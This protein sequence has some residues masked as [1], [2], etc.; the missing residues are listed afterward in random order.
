[1]GLPLIDRR[2]NVAGAFRAERASV[3]G[4]RVVVVDDVVTTGS[5]VAELAR[6]LRRAGAVSVDVWCVARAVG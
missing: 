6:E 2:A 5:T 1:M 3:V 4:R